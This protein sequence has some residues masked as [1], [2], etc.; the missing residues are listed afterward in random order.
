MKTKEYIKEINEYSSKLSD[1]NK[2]K[3]DEILLKIRFSK[4][5][6]HDAEEFSHHCLDLFLQAEKE[7]KCIEE[8]IGKED[9]AAFCN[10]YISEMQNGYSILERLYWQVKYI[11]MILLI[12]VGIYEMLIGSLVGKWIKE[13]FSTS[14]P[15]TVSLII[16][17]IVAIGLVYLFSSK[18]YDFYKLI[19]NKKFNI[20]LYIFFV[21]LIGFF[22]LSKLF[23]S[24]ILFNINYF[25]FIIVL[26]IICLLQNYFEK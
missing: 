11:P 20:C 15:V 13:G 8:V 12:Y 16:D 17:T 5:N 21:V 1:E 18:A 4:I 2:K 3:F 25:A 7:G 19:D 26:S 9:I 10:E 23:F 24:H 14:T 6:E 22:V